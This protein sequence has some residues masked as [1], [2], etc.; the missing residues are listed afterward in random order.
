MSVAEVA[1]NE[2]NRGFASGVDNTV[3]H[4]DDVHKSFAGLHALSDVDLAQRATVKGNSDR[5][6]LRFRKPG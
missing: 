1:T 6:T 2:P 4:I 5:F 3:L